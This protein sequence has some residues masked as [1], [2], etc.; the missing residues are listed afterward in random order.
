MRQVARGDGTVLCLDVG[1]GT[2]DLLLWQPD[3]RGEN[4]IHLVLPSTTRILARE[5]AE[6]TRRGLGL[7][8]RGELMG[9]GPSAKAVR[10]HLEAGLPVHAEPT[11]AQ[12]L[13]DD[14]EEVQALG[15]T[16]VDQSEAARL[17]KQ[18]HVEIRMGDLRLPE[19]LD[20][21]EKLG[22]PR[23]EGLAVAVQDHGQAPAGVSDRVF[24][25]RLWAKLL[26]QSRRLADLFYLSEEVPPELTRMQAVVRLVDGRLPLVAADT[27]PPALWGARLAAAAPRVL[28]VNY[29]NGHTLASLVEGGELSGLFEHHTRLLSPD[30][31]EA[32]L[33]RFAAGELLGQDVFRDGGHGTLPVVAPFALEEVTLSV[34][35]PG[36]AR[37]RELR[38]EQHEASIH[39]DMMITGCWGLLEG[40]RA[41]LLA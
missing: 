23:P 14:L 28:A 36:R 1:M 39:G 7:V 20:G 18:G 2:N 38:L 25:F 6:A 26:E 17:V 27:G 3:E 35:G 31:M 40:Y 32:Y 10:R 8:L 34:T 15:V 22:A 13:D 30:R 11:A 24:R 12:T 19:L 37:F 5:I 4:Q 21:L 29:G 33:R 41:R 16:L 9:G